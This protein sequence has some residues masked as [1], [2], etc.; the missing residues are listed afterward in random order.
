MGTPD[1]QGSIQKEFMNSEGVG[2]LSLQISLKLVP[3]WARNFTIGKIEA[4]VLDLGSTAEWK[5]GSVWKIRVE[6]QVQA[7]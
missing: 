2:Y 3:R 6:E 4:T 7:P 1:T 5:R